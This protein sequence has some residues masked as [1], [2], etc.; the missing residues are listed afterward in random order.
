[1]V[2]EGQESSCSLAEQFWLG[3]SQTV[4]GKTLARLE[5][6]EV[7]G[8]AV[9]VTPSCN[10][11]VGHWLETSIIPHKG[12]SGCLSVVTAESPRASNPREPAES[13]NDSYVP[14]FTLPYCIC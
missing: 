6:S 2:S 1:M 11:H 4:S 9:Q 5:S 14:S 10:W 3:V 7:V 13:G 12:L 8:F